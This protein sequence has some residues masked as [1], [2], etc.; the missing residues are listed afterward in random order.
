MKSFSISLKY[1]CNGMGFG[2]ISYLCILTFLYHGVRPTISGTLS[3]LGLSGLIGLLSMIMRSDLPL[4][5]SL[6]IHLSGT[7]LI[8]WL[9]VTINHWGMNWLSILLFFIIYA[10]IWLI[11]VLEQRRAVNR[12]NAAIRQKRAHN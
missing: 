6:L 9:M 10:V 12:I 1:F 7:F 11:C 3:V 2:A 5:I 8:F 4:T